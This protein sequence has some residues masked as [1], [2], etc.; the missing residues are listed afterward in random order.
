MQELL[1][2]H[3]MPSQD[4]LLALQ[5][6][7]DGLKADE[8]KQRLREHGRNRLKVE[9]PTS[10]LR[11]LVRQIG[12][13]LMLVLAIALTLSLV[14]GKVTDSLLTIAVIV[15]N[16][17]MGFVQEYRADRA[18]YALKTFLPLMASVRRDGRVVSISAEEIVPGDI[19]LL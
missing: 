19:L 4:V 1:P 8:A 9:K 13:P 11:I 18:L 12:S 5:S 10:A 7:R 6:S 17:I 16:V 2:W 3:H 14:L 15:V